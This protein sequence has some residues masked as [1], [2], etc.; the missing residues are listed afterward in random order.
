MIYQ[1]SIENEV[2]AEGVGLHTGQK[3]RVVLKPAKENTGIIFKRTDIKVPMEIKV[4]P[5]AVIETR[6]SSTI[7][8][9]GYK[10]ST[11]EHLMHWVWIIF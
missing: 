3:V 9:D 8:K 7:G 2:S 4:D 5:Q 1:K 6:L 10:I 11:V